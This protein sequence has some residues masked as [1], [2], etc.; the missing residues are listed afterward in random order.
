MGNL[1]AISSLRTISRH[2]TIRL[3][4]AVHQHEPRKA[5]T[6]P[7]TRYFLLCR[8]HFTSHVASPRLRR[9]AIAGGASPQPQTTVHGTVLSITTAILLASAPRSSPHN[10]PGNPAST[11]SHPWSTTPCSTVWALRGLG[12]GMYLDIGS[13]TYLHRVARSLVTCRLPIDAVHVTC[14]L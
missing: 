14:K 7:S 13:I 2:M 11:A 6:F 3:K 5:S 9:L 12:Y 10:T 1:T 8:P 4:S